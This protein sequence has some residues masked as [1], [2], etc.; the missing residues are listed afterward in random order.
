MQIGQDFPKREWKLLIKLHRR[1]VEPKVSEIGQRL[2]YRVSDISG[3]KAFRTNSYIWCYIL[4][5]QVSFGD[6]ETILTG[7]LGS[8]SGYWYIERG[9]LQEEKLPVK[10]KKKL[11]FHAMQFLS[12]LMEFKWLEILVGGMPRQEICFAS[13]IFLSKICYIKQC[14]CI[15]HKWCKMLHANSNTLRHFN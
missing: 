13:L 10:K 2:I 12:A 3:S 7:S 11:E 15:Q 8:T 9:L 14:I 1:T 5:L 4:S 6:W